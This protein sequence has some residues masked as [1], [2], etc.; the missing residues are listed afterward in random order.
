V[1]FEV[2]GGVTNIQTIAAGRGTGAPDWLIVAADLQPALDAHP[3]EE[4][5]DAVA[6]VMD[7]NPVGALEILLPRYG[8]EAVCATQQ[9][10]EP[11]ERAKAEARLRVLERLSQTPQVEECTRALSGR[12]EHNPK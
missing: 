11:I 12:L 7:A 8:A 4:M 5:K 10:G 3:A 1:Y 9:E 2:V 6:V